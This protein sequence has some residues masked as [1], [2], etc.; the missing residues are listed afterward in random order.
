MC[1]KKRNVGFA[2]PG[3]DLSVKWGRRKQLSPGGKVPFSTHFLSEKVKQPLCH[4]SGRQSAF[5]GRRVIR[6]RVTERPE[7]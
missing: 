1:G 3:S 4:H 7:G 6:S 2:F 5:S